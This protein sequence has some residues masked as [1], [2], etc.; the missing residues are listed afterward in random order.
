MPPDVVLSIANLRA[1]SAGL[2]YSV[3]NGPWTVITKGLEPAGF[4]LWTV[5]SQGTSNLKLRV[6][7][8]S[9]AGTAVEAVSSSMTVRS[10]AS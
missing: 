4:Y 8:V 7:A 5:P 9:Q 1:G 10:A 3:D 2:S 6:T